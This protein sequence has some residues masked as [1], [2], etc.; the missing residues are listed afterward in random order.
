MNMI[1]FFP[2]QAHRRA[3]SALVLLLAASCGPR[4]EAPPAQGEAAA[5][6]AVQAPGGPD[7]CSVLT[8]AEIQAAVGWTVARSEPRSGRGYSNCTWSSEKGTTVLPP[9]TVEAGII[10][11]LTNFPCT[12]IDMPKQFA[13]SAA[14][15]E[16]RRNVYKGTSYEAANPSVEPVDGL[17]V[18]AVLHE[19][20]GLYSLEMFLGVEKTAFVTLWASADA[21]RSL[22]EKVLSRLR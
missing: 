15:A 21:A 4:E 14:M 22:G 9:E 6:P 18:P 10:P 12:T 3:C 16:F 17:G 11:C 13:T 20:G 19:L 1:L 8:A 2:R 5:L 7:P